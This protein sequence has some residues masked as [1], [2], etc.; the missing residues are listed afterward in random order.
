MNFPKHIKYLNRLFTA[1]A[2]ATLAFVFIAALSVSA[3]KSFAPMANPDIDQCGNGGRPAPR[4]PCTG[5]NWQNGNINVNNAQYI[6]GES[7]PYRVTFS[8][9]VGS[10]SSLTLEWD[11]TKAGK[12][13]LDYLTTYNR[14]E[15]TGNDPCNGVAGCVLATNTTFLIPLDPD[16]AA[17]FD[18]IPGN[19]DD[20]TQAPGVFTLFGGTITSVS[21]Y[22][23]SGTYAGDSTRSVTVNFTFG[24]TG[25]I[26]LAWSG[27]IGRRVD[28]GL[29][30]SAVAISGSPYH[31]RIGGQDRSMSI[32]TVIFPGSVTIIKLVTNLSSPQTNDYSSVFSFGFTSSANFGTTSFSLIDSNPAQFLGASQPNANIQL[33][34]AA[35]TITVT[36]LPTPGGIYSLGGLNCVET[37]GGLPNILNT[38]VNFATSTASIIVE[39]GESIT[40]TFSSTQLIPSAALASITGRVVTADGSGIRGARLVLTDVNTGEVRYATTSSFGYYDFSEL[41][42]ENF[43]V[44]TISSKRYSFLNDSRS[45]T[46]NGDLSDVDFVTSP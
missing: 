10:S 17:G 23:L 5:N 43:Y 7:V 12:H 39:E 24:S 28:W 13:A 19:G 21:A 27:H 34:G 36:E 11:V 35:N 9:T 16:V 3:Q 1:S 6:E 31:M 2:L 29:S 44:L 40:C 14:S 8:G 30:N 26:V 18:Q 20:I 4:Q 22:G 42:V 46:L 15:V 32:G 25:T 41:T 45:F 38:T 37:A 33:F